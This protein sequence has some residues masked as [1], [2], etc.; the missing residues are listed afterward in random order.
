M[1]SCSSFALFGYSVA[2]YGM[3]EIDT[4]AARPLFQSFPLA[5]VRQAM[6]YNMIQSRAQRQTASQMN[7]VPCGVVVISKYFTLL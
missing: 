3:A 7:Y 4:L 1:R 2:W 6:Q 5:T